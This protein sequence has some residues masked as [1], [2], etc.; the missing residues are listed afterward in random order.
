[1]YYDGLQYNKAM[2]SVGE[3]QGEDITRESSSLILTL[4]DSF[5]NYD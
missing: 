2:F 3:T 5:A 1:M 4:F